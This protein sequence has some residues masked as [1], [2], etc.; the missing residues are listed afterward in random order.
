MRTQLAVHVLGLLLLARV[1]EPVFG[2]KEF[3]K[4]VVVVA[5]ATGGIV[6][7]ALYVGYAATMVPALLYGEYG[8]FQGVLAGLLVALKQIM[9]LH[10]VKLLG[11]LHLQVK[12][13]ESLCG[14]QSACN[15]AKT[16]KQVLT[17][18]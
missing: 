17:S 5:V 6:F 18:S 9:P 1:I 3:L 11:A 7:A 4:L 12:V 8:G 16:V 13:C 14:A 10:D 15:R 2:S